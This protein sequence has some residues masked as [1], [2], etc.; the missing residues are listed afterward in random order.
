M[1]G[2]QI[3]RI[4]IGRFHEET[5]SFN[6]LVC[7]LEDFRNGNYWEGE[8]ILSESRGMPSLIGG[9]IDVV[10]ENGGVCIP[11]IHM[12]SRSSSGIVRRR[13]AQPSR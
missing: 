10:E 1:S 2:R 11:G 6:P 9:I 7:G 5:N 4:L 3:P 8:E 13:T 12:Q